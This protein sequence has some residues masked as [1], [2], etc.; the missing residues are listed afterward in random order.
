[1]ICSRSRAAARAVG[2]LWT[3]GIGFAAL[4]WEHA[5]RVKLW[6]IVL[7]D[8]AAVGR[9]GEGT[10]VASSGEVAGAS[11]SVVSPSRLSRAARTFPSQLPSS[12][13]GMGLVVTTSAPRSARC[14]G[15]EG[16]PRGPG[17]LRLWPSIP[18]RWRARLRSAR[19]RRSDFE[20]CRTV[21][22]RG[23]P[24]WSSRANRTL[25]DR[26]RRWRPGR[27]WDS[28]G[29]RTGRRSTFLV[30]TLVRT[31]GS[32]LRTHFAARR[33]NQQHRKE[34]VRVPRGRIDGHEGLDK[35]FN[36]LGGEWTQ[37][38]HVKQ[39]PHVL[40][41]VELLL[42]IRKLILVVVVDQRNQDVVGH[43]VLIV[44]AGERQ[45]FARERD[46]HARQ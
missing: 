18:P 30:Q 21:D 10:G 14:R 37:L 23:Q 36:A 25:A 13:T 2:E 38:L 22:A 5:G 17:F 32:S 20:L 15:S 8:L 3:S 19:R 7:R 33:L 12:S 43:V 29:G 35:R 27:R 45:L 34:Q 39:T 28:D 26:R 11:S 1:M 16:S 9:N 31:S 6:E 42:V 41:P 40:P 46:D 24:A 4:R 44:D